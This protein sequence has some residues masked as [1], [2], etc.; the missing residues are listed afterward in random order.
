MSA[1][2]PA[3]TGSALPS[4]YR[5]DDYIIDRVLGHGGFGIT[6]LARDTKLNARVAIKEYF[7]RALAARDASY[8][9][10]PITEG[11]TANNSDYRWGLQEFLKEARALAR[12]KHNHIV[13]VLRFLETNGTAYMV[14]EYEQGESLADTLKR[15]GGF[16]NEAK[17]MQ[18]FLPVL[19]GLQAVHDAG[20]LHLDIKPDNIYL[21]RDGQPMLIDFGSV[22]QV[23]SGSSRTDKVALTPAYSA[24]EQYPGMG[25]KGPWTDI[26]SLGATLYRC[27]TGKPPV[28]SLQRYQATRNH[29]VD[30]YVSATEFERPL[31]SHHIR[32]CIDLA[33]ALNA[34]DRPHS[35]SQLQ[36]GLMGQRITE[37]GSRKI[38][39]PSGNL[40]YDAIPQAHI[41]IKPRRKR[42]RRH[43]LESLFFTT[44]LSIAVA[45]FSLQL[46]VRF[47]VMTQ[48]Q[49]IDRVQ[50]L[51][52]E[53]IQLANQRLA[54]VDHFTYEKWRIHL[55]PQKPSTP[56]VSTASAAAPAPVA[57]SSKTSRFS[58]DMQVEKVLGGRHGAIRALAF[59]G[60]GSLLAATDAR[61]ETR[62]WNVDTGKTV[63]R[64][65]AGSD[66]SA[67]MAASADGHWLARRHG[68]RVVLWDAANGKAGPSFDG[69]PA[70]PV[71]LAFTPDGSR[72]AVVEGE[73]SISLWDIADE[74]LVY[75]IDQTKHKVTG[76]SFSPNGTLFA[77]ADDNGKVTI[78]SVSNGAELSQITARHPGKSVDDLVYSTDGSWLATSGPDGFLKLYDLTSD[79]HDERLPNPPADVKAIVFSH[80]H[81]WVLT[82][83]S[84]KTIQLWDIKQAAL[85]KQWPAGT[86]N[87]DAL[88]IS[89]DD[90]RVAS[91]GSDGR[92]RIWK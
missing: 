89:A 49:I 28:D 4:A 85:A 11:T 66:T 87:V 83:G 18:I 17:L 48:D 64:F 3:S 32:E 8:T 71:M 80:D 24:I 19:S 38:I 84:G 44:V 53:S 40:N 69:F 15:S 14:M 60:N 42:R 25:E 36:K 33:L 81:R 56:V 21:R 52:A 47:G 74:Q 61:G 86:A 16:L 62:I 12:F 73:Q 68:D 7:P 1:V 31:F 29:K 65:R 75:R 37:E 57:P 10:T 13:R 39:R 22:R 54:D 23:K 45:V 20:L 82:A 30:P 92:I 63:K 35:A 88:A 78:W 43:W 76:I 26:Y 67:V 77:T 55:L 51:R 5:L 79:P 27:V 9:I 2:K 50:Q 59:L 91:G 72:L 46:M 6:Y 34:E 70:A 90:Q 41:D 58:S